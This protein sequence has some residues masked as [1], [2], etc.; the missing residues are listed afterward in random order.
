MLEEPEPRRDT[1][2]ATEEGERTE[3]EQSREESEEP[4]GFEEPSESEDEGGAGVEELPSVAIQAS[5]YNPSQGIISV[6]SA[7]PNNI[8]RAD[9][10]RSSL[11]EFGDEPP[12]QTRLG[13]DIFKSLSDLKDKLD[14]VP[15]ALDLVGQA[16]FLTEHSSD[17]NLDMSRVESAV[18][19]IKDQATRAQSDQG[20]Q[21]DPRYLDALAND[22][23]TCVIPMLVLVLH[24]SFAIGAQE[25]NAESNDTLPPEGAFTQTTVQYMLWI[26]SWLI[27][28]Q[29]TLTQDLAHQTNSV[30]AT[31][32]RN[33]PENPTQSRE[34]FGVMVRKWRD[35][36]KAQVEAFNEEVE[37]KRDIHQKKQRDLA[38]KRMKEQAEKRQLEDDR[39]YEQAVWASWGELRTLPR[40]MAEKWHKATAHW[41]S[42]ILGSSQTAR[43]PPSTQDSTS[44]LGQAQS[45]SPTLSTS[46]ARAPQPQRR[47]APL[48]LDYPAWPEDEV[49]WF[50]SELN[51]PDRGRDYLYVCAET[52]DRPLEEVRTE[53]ERLRRAGLYRPQEAGRG[54]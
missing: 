34:R 1:R 49:E 10:I 47:P 14:D 2:K 38:I 7:H 24:A 31:N 28:L 29:E 17:V 3:E 52:L 19:K 32:Q 15:N 12:A 37:R 35:H 33:D 20:N 6:S 48:V 16:R 53:M 8:W 9:L 4:V 51:R 23:S 18:L 54:V 22:L 27:R 42:S 50:L 25:P 39:R 21:I 36:L 5:S 46:G 41:P 43:S 44:S 40:P 11:F 26:T 30:P 13:R 45:R